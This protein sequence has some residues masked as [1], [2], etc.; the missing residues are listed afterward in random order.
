[1]LSDSETCTVPG[2]MKNT[3]CFKSINLRSKRR[4][5]FKEALLA[6]LPNSRG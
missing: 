4:D 3:L 6:H 1:M 2:E 5:M